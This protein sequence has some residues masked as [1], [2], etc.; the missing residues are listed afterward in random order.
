MSQL[1]KNPTSPVGKIIVFFVVTQLLALWAGI[2]LLKMAEAV[3]ELHSLSVAPYDNPDEPLNAAYFLLIVVCGAA[4]VLLAIRFY[5]GPWLF[6]ILEFTTVA[7]TTSVLVF[8]ILLSLQ[9]LTPDM[10][11]LVGTAIGG[12]FAVSKFFNPS[13]KNA[14]AILSSAGVG[15]LFGF[16]AGIVPALLFIL[17]ISV[18]DYVAVFKTRHMLAMSRA[19][20][21]TELA[22]TVTAK[23]TP[24]IHTSSG[25]V[26]QQTS[27]PS[28]SS[29]A[30]SAA[31]AVHATPN[32]DGLARL[33][34]GTGD[35]A[36]P[37]MLAVSA[38]PHAGI[39]GSAAVAIGSTVSLYLLLN[40]VMKNRVALPAMPPISLGALVFLL[41]ALLLGA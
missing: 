3:P 41:I 19:L 11:L 40:F 21:T 14:A 18:Y 28:H 22:F 17:G 29:H 2:S 6:R 31:Q 10:A 35:L 37:A 5:K 34:L 39:A 9:I 32:D 8:G 24:E 23:A 7:G 38:Y 16:S 20:G 4:G 36:V 13:L 1:F 30:P 27:Q 26:S 25:G 15:A 33:D 12:L